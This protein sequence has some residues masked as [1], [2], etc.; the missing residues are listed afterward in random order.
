MKKSGVLLV[1]GLA[2][3]MILA[4]C[5]AGSTPSEGVPQEEGTPDSLTMLV[6]ASPSADGL[7][8]LATEYESETG[9]AIEFVEVPY[10]QLATRIILASQSGES[11]FDM[12]QVDG[13]T[14]PQIVAANGLLSLDDYIA[15]DADYDYDDF[16]E[17]L[18]EYA[19]Q[20][21]VSYGLPLSTEPYLQWI[22]TDLYDELGLEAAVTWDDV[23][24][25]AD[26][27]QEAGH[28]GAVGVYGASGSAHHFNAVLVGSGGRLLDSETYRPMLDTEV[29][30]VALDRYIDLVEYGPS[31][32]ASAT[33]FDAVNSFSQLDVGQ[34]T[35]LASGWWSTINNPDESPNA[36]NYGTFPPA[37]QEAGDYDPAAVLY[38]W[39]AGI[40]SASPHQAAAWD[41]LAWALSKENA[42][43]FI[44]AGAPPPARISTTTNPEFLEQL[45]YLAAV[46]ESV[47]SG[48]PIDRIP[49][50]S[51][52]ITALSQTLNSIATGQMTREEG[53][54][55]AQ[56][57]LMN[58]L[59][60]SGRYKG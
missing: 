33:I 30:A 22:R 48:V 37:M 23:Y 52:I 7:R 16:P 25:N 20:D 1:A 8:A 55:A 60:Q 45:P 49:E 31:G 29:A 44:D 11:T 4:G 57:Q 12:A 43:A 32:T 59:V 18:K 28:Y 54:V 56:D 27:L 35:T 41:F 53:L 10:E 24:E 5:S 3:A 40:S 14:L 39:V 17:G 51:Q 15:D 2:A 38:G 6:T 47:E 50:M 21:G 9:V 34:M 42:A 19:K 58:I 13:F 26:A 36:G 46:G